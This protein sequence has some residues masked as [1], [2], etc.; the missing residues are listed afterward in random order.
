MQFI[1]ILIIDNINTKM[2]L[3]T[4]LLLGTF[5]LSQC[6]SPQTGLTVQGKVEG[7]EDL[8][9]YLDHKS[10]DNA[11][12]PL[13]NLPLT[14]NGEFSFNFPEGLKPGVYRVRIGAKSVDLVLR[15]DESVV[16]VKGNINNFQNFDYEVSGSEL[17]SQFK[18]QISGMVKGTKTKADVDVFMNSDIDPLLAMTLSLSTAPPNAAQY[19][20]Y[21]GIS[22]KLTAAYPNDDVAPQFAN[23]AATMA[24]QFNAQQ[25]QYK[26]RLGQPAPD[27]V[28]ADVNGK[29]R[30][31]SD[32]KGKVVLL[33]F[34]ASWCGPCRKSN[35]HLVQTYHK[36]K[37]DGF[38]VFSVSLDGLDEKTKRRFPASQLADQMQK[39]K[40]R[41]L[42]AIEKDKLVWDGHVSD[43]KKWESQGAALYGV[44]SIPTTFLIDK[45]GNIA[46]LNPRTNLEAELKKLI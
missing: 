37:D 6:S 14:D 4:F 32:L 20:V 25:S 16:E 13:G 28:M 31:L 24:K 44:R 27:I 23:F 1:N 10:L 7:A 38:T 34:W 41:W 11:I 36:Y 21:E 26:V 39:Q 19:A 3:F 42:D 35:P 30:K 8:T 40:K 17:S 9:A 22:K 2:R 12:V 18:D 5:L 46:A 45:N 33:D 43:L 29:V 15:G